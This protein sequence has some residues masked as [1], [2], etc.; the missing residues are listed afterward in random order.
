MKS[1]QLKTKFEIKFIYFLNKW[2]NVWH[3][4]INPIFKHYAGW[5]F[6]KFRE[7]KSFRVT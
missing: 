2:F 6:S 4:G 1:S 3:L 5:V 7:M